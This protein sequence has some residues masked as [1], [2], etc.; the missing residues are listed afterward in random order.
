MK[1]NLGHFT[2][3]TAVKLA[4]WMI[5]L[6]PSLLYSQSRVF[7]TK[8]NL[9]VAGPGSIKATS[10]D[11]TCV[12]CHTP[13]TPQ[14]STQLW[15]H[16]LSTATYELYSSDYLT[17]INYSAPS[18]PKW[19]SKL[20]LSC[21][22]G[23]VAIGAVYNLGGTSQTILLQDNVTMMPAHAP[24]NIG[25]SLKNDHPVGFIYENAKDPELV[26]RT[27]P[28]G[29]KVKLDPDVPS[30]TVECASC[31]EPHDN[32]N[33]H[34][35]RVDNTNAFLCTFCHSKAGWTDAIHRTS[36]QSFAT[37]DSTTTT[38]GEWSC[39]SCHQS[40]GGLGVPYLLKAEEENTCFL[41]GCHGKSLTGTN[42]K[43]IQSEFEKMY[44]H[45]TVSTTGKHRNPDNASSLG[46]SNRHAECQDCHDSHQA[47]KG[48]HAPRGN[49]LSGV[50][51][52]TAGVLPGFAAEWTQPV[53]FSE[54]KPATQENQICLKCHSAYAFGTV[55]EGVTSITGPSGGF[56]TDQ[57]MEFNGANHSAHPVAYSSNAQAGS[58][59]PKALAIDQMSLAWSAVGN[60]TMYCS[61]C[62]GNDKE[63]SATT[64]QGP[65][66][67]DAKFMLTGQ[68]KYWPTNAFGQLWSLGD[69]KNN[70]NNWRNDMFCANCHP[71]TTGGAMT[72][73]VH[74]ADAHQLA[75]VKCV[76]CHVTVPHGAKRSR[77]IGYAS[78]VS[79][80]NYSG[81]GTFDRLVISGFRKASS[82]T[83]YAK[84]D[85]ST[86]G[87]CHGVQF[88]AYE[89]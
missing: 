51:R 26:A 52:G 6:L 57:A 61:D 9:T 37:T 84:E 69:V 27:W 50:L 83:A 10:Q 78:D 53:S 24:G 23:T 56:M 85:C 19:R 11:N 29:T 67:S 33:G 47:K 87:L 22:D 35:L 18:Q 41:S 46:A 66:G 8:H 71:M 63:A 3:L 43:N 86:P 40:H 34:F 36:M 77:L 31:H 39:R 68:A 13:H 7:E 58:Q 42:T 48:L 38:M 82:P 62:H 70:Q 4:V 74:E 15:N 88:G 64:P 75:E 44:V 59:I 5:A 81:P 20:C 76:T 65:H 89:P 1:N 21:H 14:T 80:Y 49:E 72:N 30:G 79:P 12:F 54:L 2:G 32:T 28:W 60:Q 25:T 17:S 73:K 55:F 45:P 16:S